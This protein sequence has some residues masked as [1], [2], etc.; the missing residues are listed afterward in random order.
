MP[1]AAQIRTSYAACGPTTSGNA[2]IAGKGGSD[3]DH[4]VVAAYGRSPGA[5]QSLEA[6]SAALLDQ[7]MSNWSSAASLGSEKRWRMMKYG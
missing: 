1:Y 3:F 2:W 5:R 7:G 4:A 6:R